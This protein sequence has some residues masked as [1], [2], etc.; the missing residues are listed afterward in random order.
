MTNGNFR[1]KFVDDTTAFETIPRNSFSLLKFATNDFYSFSEEPRMKLNPI[2]C[3][4]MIVN[5]M[6]NHNFII[7]PVSIGGNTIERVLVYKLLGVYISNGLK[8]THHV[9]YVIKKANNRLYSLRVLKQCGSPPVSLAKVLV[10]I[11]PPILEYAVPARMAKH[12]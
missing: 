7:N 11:V 8:W 12:T 4:E 9:D 1:I 2:K 5:F 10:T 6:T 3:R